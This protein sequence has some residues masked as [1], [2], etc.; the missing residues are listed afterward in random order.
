MLAEPSGT[1]FGTLPGEAVTERGLLDYLI[2][3]RIQ[4]V[5]LRGTINGRLDKPSEPVP[6]RVAPRYYLAPS[7][8]A[9]IDNQIMICICVRHYA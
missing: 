2:L 3:V 4:L 6:G 1:V 7:I 9:E 8:A 5:I